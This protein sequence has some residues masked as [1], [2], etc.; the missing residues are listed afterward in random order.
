MIAD[1]GL[2]N[3]KVNWYSAGDLY[4]SKVTS[5]IEHWRYAVDLV[6]AIHQFGKPQVIE[7]VSHGGRTV[8]FYVWRSGIFSMRLARCFTKS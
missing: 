4:E 3:P 5:Q 2:F 8:D 7:I 6:E 1:V